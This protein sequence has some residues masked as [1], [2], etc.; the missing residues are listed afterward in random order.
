MLCR[1]LHAPWIEKFLERR[2]WIERKVIEDIG[3]RIHVFPNLRHLHHISD[4]QA[5]RNV[6]RAHEAPYHIAVVPIAPGWREGLKE[7]IA[8]RG[9]VVVLPDGRQESHIFQPQPIPEKFNRKQVLSWLKTCKRHRSRCNPKAPDVKG[10]R[11]IDC[12]SEHLTI[13]DY[14]P[15]NNYVALSYVWGQSGSAGPTK[16]AVPRGTTKR[17][18]LKLP[19]DIPLTIRDAIEVTKALRYRYLWID[20]Y[21]IDQDNQE[22]QRAQFSRMGDIYAGSQ[23]AIF[24]L[25]DDSNAGLPGVSSTPRLGQEESRSGPFR[26]I[27]TMPDPHESIK[28]AKWST[29]AW[30]YQEGLFSTR[31]LFFTNHQ[32]YFECNAMN[33]AESFKSNLDIIHIRNGQRFR[34]YHRAGQF[35]CG[36]ST[37]YSHLDVRH[38][39]ANHRKI[40]M[41]RRCQHQIAQYTRR[42]LTNKDDML[43]AFA[44]IARFYAK[45]AAMI[46]SL[47]GIPIPFPIANLP[48]GNRQEGLDHLSYALAWL[49]EA[50]NF[51]HQFPRRIIQQ[52]SPSGNGS[53]EWKQL[54]WTPDINP[55]AQRRRGF[56]SWSWAGWFGQ[57]RS[58]DDLPYCWT[59]LLSS[60]VQIGFPNG[61]LKDYY[62]LVHQGVSRYK[63]YRIREL[64]TADTLHF[65][66]F[67]LSP[68]KLRVVISRRSHDVD[69]WISMGPSSWDELH[70]RL[71]SGEYQC[72]VLGTYGEPRRDVY[73]AIQAAD[74][75]SKTAKKRRIDLFERRESAVIVC[76]VVR[77]DHVRGVSFRRGLLKVRYYYEV[78]G[79]NALRDWNTGPRRSFVLR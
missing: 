79:E 75:K 2:R 15:G 18:V 11:L 71:E 54:P 72:V 14:E 53:A 69:A 24:A 62:E 73:R 61:D 4:F 43:N 32:I 41:V 74:K 44:A 49:H 68:R 22:E 9:L 13:R 78:G 23:L 8:A 65:D 67:V 19:E 76:L 64:L 59:S 27:S 38:N 3:D 77:T 20:K 5:G 12:K 56:P 55:K 36:N 51:D 63:Q 42:E 7:H 50:D 33:E 1:Q 26:F 29:R 70:A 58:R 10:M 28:R 30:T 66:A 47:A 40:D 34:A 60:S 35:V 31:R 48:S 6:L 16:A 45:T 37:P 17:T 52:T 46:A 39:K 25:G 57:V 21:C